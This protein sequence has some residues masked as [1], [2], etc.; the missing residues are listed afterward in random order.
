MNRSV[1]VLAGVS[2]LALVECRNGSVTGTTSASASS[3]SGSGTGGGPV[4]V[5]C[6]VKVGEPTA[7][8]VS[9]IMSAQWFP[10]LPMQPAPS[11]VTVKVCSREDE[12]C[13]T[14]ADTQITNPGGIAAFTVPTPPPV[15]FDGYFELTGGNP[16]AIWP[17][18][19]YE[20]NPIEA[21]GSEAPLALTPALLGALE[22]LG[23]AELD[24]SRGLV[25]ARIIGCNRLQGAGFTLEVSGADAQSK[26]GYF[27][28][29][30]PD[31]TATSTDSSGLAYALNLPPG[32]VTLVTRDPRSGVRLGKLDVWIRA[33]F[34]TE[35]FFYP[36][37]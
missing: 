28:S 11:G 16:Q 3:S 2:L 10:P 23:G 26:I 17:L 6:P 4:E 14:P 18:L 30:V 35:T 20:S 5:T 37:P 15:G 32:K 21:S 1:P 27:V 19:W 33:G 29:N 22:K 34:M 24:P 8:K 13:A 9:F 36:T 7:M 31:K 12:A 25:G